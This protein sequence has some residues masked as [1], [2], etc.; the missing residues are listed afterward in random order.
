MIVKQVYCALVTNLSQSEG[1]QLK[2]TS[3]MRQIYYL[4][5]GIKGQQKP[6]ICCELI[7]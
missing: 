4:Q 2:E 6:R 5:I 1:T 3:Y 7:P